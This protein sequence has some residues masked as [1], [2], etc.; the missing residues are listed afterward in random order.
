MKNHKIAVIRGDGIG[1]EVVEEGI[2]V[3]KEVSTGR[4]DVDYIG[5]VRWGLRQQGGQ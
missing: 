4:I 1:I 5:G 2:K 3:L